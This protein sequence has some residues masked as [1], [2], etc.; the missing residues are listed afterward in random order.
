MI[1]GISLF[2]YFQF[3]KCCAVFENCLRLF[4]FLTCFCSFVRE[5]SVKQ[6]LSILDIVWKWISTLVKKDDLTS[7]NTEEFILL[8]TRVWCTLFF[9]SLGNLKLC[10]KVKKVHQINTFSIHNF[11]LMNGQTLFEEWIFFSFYSDTIH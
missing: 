3:R 1:L 8:L 9:C 4:F 6:R 11:S 10:Q 5:A 2:G 7:N